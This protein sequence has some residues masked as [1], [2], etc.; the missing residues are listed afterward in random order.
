MMYPVSF[1]K[2]DDGKVTSL[3]YDGTDVYLK[4]KD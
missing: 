2:N 4:N 3:I 1:R